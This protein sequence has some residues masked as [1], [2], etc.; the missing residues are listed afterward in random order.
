MKLAG[1]EDVKHAFEHALTQCEL[2]ASSHA[3]QPREWPS[4][5]S[6]AT[7][8]SLQDRPLPPLALLQQCPIDLTRFESATYA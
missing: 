4:A 1:L 2:M 5:L 6:A 8:R 3:G 7:F